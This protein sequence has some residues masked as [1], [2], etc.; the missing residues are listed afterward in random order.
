MYNKIRGAVTDTGHPQQVSLPGRFHVGHS[1]VLDSSSCISSAHATDELN[2]VQFREAKA[3]SPFSHTH[4]PSKACETLS[5]PAVP[6]IL[7]LV[8][9]PGE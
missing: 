9:L 4:M 5:Y 8:R 3:S 7:R 1:L 2:S 6:H